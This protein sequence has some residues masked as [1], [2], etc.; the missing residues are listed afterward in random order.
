[1]S[2]KRQNDKP[3]NTIDTLIGVNTEIKGDISFSGGL[4]VDGKVTGNILSEGGDASGTLVLSE[5]AVVAG[6]VTVP[7]LI[8]NGRIQGNVRSIES[9]EL[10][11]KA[12]IVGD[13]YYKMI[14][15][16]LGASVNG[17]LV[18]DTEGAAKGSVTHLK[19]VSGAGEADKG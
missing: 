4:R 7:H 3:C 11:P 16:A 13:V 5:H 14:E 8:I 19:P 9:I 2:V 12:E 15:M 1:M 6:N 10:Q 17:N 18:R